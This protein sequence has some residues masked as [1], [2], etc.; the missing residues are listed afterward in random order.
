[1]PFVNQGL[2]INFDRLRERSLK[3]ACLS[4]TLLKMSTNLANSELKLLIGISG[5]NV[6]KLVKDFSRSSL[7]ASEKNL[8]ISSFVFSRR[9][10]ARNFGQF[11]L[12]Y[13]SNIMVAKISFYH[14]RI[15]LVCIII[16]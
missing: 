8:V 13:E 12:S 16:C 2:C 10:F 9:M 11:T 14:T 6:I 15:E 4:T 3:G 7:K 1:M 5:R